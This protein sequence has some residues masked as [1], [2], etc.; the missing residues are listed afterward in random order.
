MHVKKSLKVPFMKDN[1]GAKAILLSGPPGIGK[2]TMATVVGKA[3]GYDLM[4]LNASDAR[5]K[6][7]LDTQVG[8]NAMQCFN[9]LSLSVYIYT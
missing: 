2:T 9:F 4:E 8:Y 1:P 6:S 5:S 3:C 7:M